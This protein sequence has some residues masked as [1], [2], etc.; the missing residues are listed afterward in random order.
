MSSASPPDWSPGT[1]LAFESERTRPAAD[2][3]AAVRRE[4]VARAVD[5]GCGPGNSTELLLARFPGATVEGFDN[6]PAMLEAA[7]ARLP[8]VRFFESD[9]STW[10]PGGEVDLVFANAA[11]QWAPDHLAHLP[12][13]LAALPGGGVLAVQMPDNLAEPT[14]A[15]MRET[16]AA[17]P[18]AERLAGAARAPLPSAPVYYS[19]L[20][21]HARRVDIWRTTYHHALPDA[22]AIVSMVE[23]TG[24]RP[25]L[26]PLDAEEKIR[27]RAEYG[28][29][30]EGAYPPVADGGRLLPFPRLFI[31]A[32]R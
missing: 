8:G 13:V 7:R 27:F 31:V 1:Y 29:R 24:L 20:R 6:S 5:V 9:M 32:E 3:L 26:A 2:L 11:Y 23:S 12:Q 17:G 16:A 15:L 30:I 25:F 21:P 18:W 28:R 19:A 10:V 4:Q 14:H 22:E